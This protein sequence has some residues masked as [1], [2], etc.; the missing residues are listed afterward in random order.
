MSSR[1]NLRDRPLIVRYA[2][3]ALFVALAIM[4]RRLLHPALTDRQPFPTFY[5][6]VTAA[7]WWGGLGPTL[8]ALVS[9][10]STPATT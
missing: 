9:N 3:A 10:P 1:M 7:A 2:I 8:F 6:S 4:A 5:V